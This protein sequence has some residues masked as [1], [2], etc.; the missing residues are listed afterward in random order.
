MPNPSRALATGRFPTRLQWCL[1]VAAATVVLAPL[2]AAGPALAA[3]STGPT[4]SLVAGNG[5]WAAAPGGPAIASGLDYPKT[6]TADGR[7][8]YDFVNGY[9]V[10][11]VDAQGILTVIAGKRGVSDTPVPGPA[12]DSPLK[13]PESIAADASG[14]IYLADYGARKVLKVST[15][16]ELSVLAGTGVKVWDVTSGPALSTPIRPSN[17]ATG[18]DG[19]V[20]ASNEHQVV[21][22]AEGQMTVIAGDGGTGTPTIGGPLGRRRPQL[23]RGR[24]HR[25]AATH[26]HRIGPRE[27]HGLH[28]PRPRG[29]RGRRRA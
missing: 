8:H 26:R 12:T 11:K 3:P 22:I 27:R 18:P 4:L 20:Y 19:A 14:N 29:Q 16:G 2:I 28:L 1:A 24:G 13:Q 10:A 5:T 23:E 15:G 21:R 17:V 6:I 9:T 25:N 7:G